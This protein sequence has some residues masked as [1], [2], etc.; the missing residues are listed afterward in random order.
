MLLS[1]SIP[2]PDEKILA[3]S[4]FSLGIFDKVFFC[5]KATSN[6]VQ[7]KC[8]DGNLCLLIRSMFLTVAL[9]S[10]TMYDL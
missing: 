10:T 2:K 7:E 6:G 9:I 4:T 1:H 3:Y 8:V 5:Y